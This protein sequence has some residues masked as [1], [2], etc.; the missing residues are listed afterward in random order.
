MTDTPADAA[1]IPAPGAASGPP[2]PPAPSPVRVLVVDDQ[3]LIRESIAAL[4]DIQPGIEVV[5][6]AADGREA[7]ARALA[8]GPHV[9]LMDVRMPVLDGVAA[10]AELAAR[11]P[12]CRVVMLTTFDDEDYVV[13]ALRAGAAGYLLKD[14][15]A[16]ELAAAVRLARAGVVQFDP[17]AAA[18]LA[19]VLDRAVPFAGLTPTGAVM[20][21]PA[22]E[23]YP[24]GERHPTDQPHATDRP[25]ATAEPTEAGW[26]VDTP[27]PGGLTPRE[28]DV[29]RLVAA[30]LNNR[31][32][33]ARLYLSEGTVKNHVSRI[34]DRL[35]LRD[36]TQAAIYARDHDLL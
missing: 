34:L 25:P 3:R 35:G 21:P 32:I 10:A 5:G 4:L 14:R 36:R 28:I 15:P 13:R 19:T 9:V 31:E 11:A 17:A 6:T 2:V 18:R 1:G 20:A 23:P 26:P 24:A 27:T 33:A 8:L 16:A 22:V 30:G 29:L 12:A 7:V